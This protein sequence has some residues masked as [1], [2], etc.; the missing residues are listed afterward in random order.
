MALRKRSGTED[1][2]PISHGSAELQM[3]LADADVVVMGGSEIIGG[4]KG[5]IVVLNERLLLSVTVL[6]GILMLV[7]FMYWVY[8]VSLIAF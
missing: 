8:T 5:A 3:V 2:V 1:H 7:A 4:Q 6:A